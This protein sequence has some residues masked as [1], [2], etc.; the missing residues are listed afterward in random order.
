M[1]RLARLAREI[2]ACCGLLSDPAASSFIEL[3]ACTSIAPN[4]LPTSTK[5]AFHTVET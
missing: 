3:A 4:A 5:K 2:I 1:N